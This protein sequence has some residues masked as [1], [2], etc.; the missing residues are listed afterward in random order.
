MTSQLSSLLTLT[1]EYCK[2]PGLNKLQLFKA[3]KQHA[4]RNLK[5]KTCDQ[6]LYP[7]LEDVDIRTG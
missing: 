2:L 6:H 5:A 4:L 7:G 1:A 3:Q